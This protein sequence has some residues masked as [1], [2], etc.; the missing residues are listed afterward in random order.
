MLRW[1][2]RALAVFGFLV[3]A[4]TLIA[5]LTFE[6]VPTHNCKRTHFDTIIV[7]G[8]P[9]LVNGQPSF[10]ERSRVSEGVKEFK[11]GRAD[12]MLFTGGAV[13]NQFVEGQVMA[14][15]A[16]SEG[17]P[18]DAIVIEG[19]AQNTIQNIYFSHQ[20]MEQKG[21][22][23]AEVV[24]SPSHLPRAGLILEHYHFQWQEHAAPWWPGAGWRELG[25]IYS[26]EIVETLVLRWYGFSPSP[27]LPPK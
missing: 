9:A 6:T 12:H 14:R 7:L 5:I 22:T 16:E 11:A 15:L 26:G 3:L 27:F 8:A 13:E 4:S 23:S 20:I 19:Q 2:V 1:I 25:L 10:E 17:V 18:A 21:W 24:S